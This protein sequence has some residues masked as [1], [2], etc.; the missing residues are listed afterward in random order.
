MESLVRAEYQKLNAKER[1]DSYIK[2]LSLGELRYQL[3]ND[4]IKQNLKV[5]FKDSHL[6]LATPNAT[7]NVVNGVLDVFTEIGN[8][9]LFRDRDITA[10][11]SIAKS[12]KRERLLG[13]RGYNNDKLHRF[14]Q[15]K[16]YQVAVAGREF[17]EVDFSRNRDIN[18]SSFLTTR[19]PSII[20]AREL[21]LETYSLNILSPQT[22]PDVLAVENGLRLW[23]V[24]ND[25]QGDNPELLE[26]EKF[27]VEYIRRVETTNLRSQFKVLDKDEAENLLYI[28]DFDDTYYNKALNA[29]LK[30]LK[31]N[32]LES[33]DGVKD[34]NDLIFYIWS[35]IYAK[36]NI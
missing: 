26:R 32:Y 34:Y 14:E 3:I 25:E 28:F 10:Q 20:H 23:D 5:G 2:P 30:Y 11:F 33:K 19:I 16:W 6:I 31:T 24:A 17:E 36:G 1:L 8:H 27:L 13:L 12:Y 4:K 9:T 15:N 29:Y 7:L 21:M 18:L 22:A 35:L